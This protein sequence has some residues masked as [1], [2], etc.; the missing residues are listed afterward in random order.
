METGCLGARADASSACPAASSLCPAVSSLS[1]AGPERWPRGAVE[2]SYAA[3]TLPSIARSPEPASGNEASHELR[4]G[5]S[6]LGEACPAGV[7]LVTHV[8]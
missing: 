5:D 7:V 1:F 8:Y 4:A 3:S 6:V 2:S